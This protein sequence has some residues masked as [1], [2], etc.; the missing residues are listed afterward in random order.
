MLLCVLAA[1]TWSVIRCKVVRDA[2][3]VND[4]LTGE[5]TRLQDVLPMI[6]SSCQMR[7]LPTSLSGS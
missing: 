1:V 3:V 5:F 6:L 7:L 4:G 2:G